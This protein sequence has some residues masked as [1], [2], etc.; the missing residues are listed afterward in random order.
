M[1]STILCVQED[2]AVGRALAMALEAD[3]HEVLLAQ[4]GRR[5]LD[6]VERQTP[7]LIVLDVYLSRQDGFEVLTSIRQ[8]P[9]A[10]EVP[11]L[12]VCGGDVTREIVARAERL[13]AAG[14]VSSSLTPEQ[15]A[16]RVAGLLDG[17][18]KRQAASAR[19]P[20]HGT[21]R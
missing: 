6:I 10:S 14:V 15:I 18:D 3:G 21:L 20:T 5:C 17:G 12:L 11:V 19:T 4:D 2:R 8:Q 16:L 9:A 1:P 13:A 7:D